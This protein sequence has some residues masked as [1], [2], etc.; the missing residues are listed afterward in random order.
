MH[1]ALD[2]R[3]KFTYG[4]KSRFVKCS[5]CNAA[6]LKSRSDVETRAPCPTCGSNR[7]TH[8]VDL[9][10]WITPRTKLRF[11]ARGAN[12]GKPFADGV[13]GSDLHR[14]SNHWMRL[15]RVIDRLRTWYYERVSDRESGAV[16]REVS[17]PLTEHQGRGSGKR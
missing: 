7:R 12:E 4:R 13:I 10:A 2:V 17:E 5:N 11:K 1:Q 9:H 6:L 14:D 16:T 15:E 8:T 3:T